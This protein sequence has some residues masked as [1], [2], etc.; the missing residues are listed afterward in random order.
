MTRHQS[1]YQGRFLS[2]L[3][4]FS[5]FGITAVH[6]QE[7]KIK[8]FVST[9]HEQKQFNGSLL[10]AEGDKILFQSQTGQSNA[11]TQEKISAKS[12]F[13]I[14]SVSKTFTS[15]A[16]LQLK[17]KGLLDLDQPV[18]KYLPDFPYENVTIRHLLSNTSGLS[19]YYSLFDQEIDADGNRVIINQDIIPVLKQKN[20]PLSF[21]PGDR[22]EYN[23]VNF[24]LAALIVEKVSGKTFHNYLNTF[25]F[26]PSGMKD[27]F[28]PVDRR[29]KSKA[30]VQLYSYPNLYSTALKNVDSLPMPFKIEGHS[31]FY[32]NGGIV[33]TAADLIKFNLALQNGK[34]LPK[35]E[36]AEAFNPTVL[37]NGK[38]VS[39][40]LDEKEVSY[41]LGWEMYTDTTH[42]K[43][44]FHDGSISGLT[45]ILI[46]NLSTKQAIVMLDNTGSN[47]V[48]ASVNALMEL[49]GNRAYVI[50]GKNL[51]REYASAIVAGDVNK[52]DDFIRNYESN[53]SGFRSS[54]RD[55]VRVGYDLLRNNLIKESLTVFYTAS[56]LY[57][58]SWNVYDSFGEALLKS[59]DTVKAQ[60][61]YQK[62]IKLN[63]ENK[64][65]VEI[66]QKLQKI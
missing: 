28:V 5:F 57:P 40:K 54:E 17:S 48:F 30:Q 51:P 65:A 56:K 8:A 19:Q 66:L 29:V 39:Y 52:G 42:G 12:Q 23:N 9:L 62:S 6:A 2:T 22:W 37:N 13:P 46:Y 3:F 18:K 59:G 15:T 24:C 25:V 38:I 11:G 58:E 1:K 64:N 7:Q 4:L 49:L 32:G 63:P 33:S 10:I 50:P 31:N 16:I 60:E 55:F 41:G 14:A 20:I 44:V 35:K 21:T 53:P 36:L 34:L 45:S 47:V 43:V 26:S 61:M 27:T